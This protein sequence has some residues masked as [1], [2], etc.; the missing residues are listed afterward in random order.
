MKKVVL[1]SCASKKKPHRA[2]AEELYVSA[3]FMGNLRYAKSQKPYDIFI[4]SAKYGL[5]EL[6]REIKPYDM[7]LKDMSSAQVR[8]WAN[9]VLEQLRRR[10]DL[11]SDHFILLAGSIYRKYLVPHMASYEI[12]LQGMAIGKQLQYL[13]A[14]TYD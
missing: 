9:G 2:K 11:Q 14:Q 3:L 10:S 5:L 12:P 7:T 4:L 6:D 8:A 1:I 13:A